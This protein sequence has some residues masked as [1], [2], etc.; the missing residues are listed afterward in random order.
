M[1][2]VLVGLLVVLLGV[3]APQHS[4]AAAYGSEAHTKK[5]ETKVEVAPRY[6]S[7]YRSLSFQWLERLP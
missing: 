6:V 1:R 2:T 3:L 5:A 7:L 4:A